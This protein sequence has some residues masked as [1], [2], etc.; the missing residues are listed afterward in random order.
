MKF[1]AFAL[2]ILLACCLTS[3]IEVC[4][5]SPVRPLLPPQPFFSH[6]VLPPREGGLALLRYYEH[7]GDSI[8][9][10]KLTNQLASR[11][12]AGNVNIGDF[13]IGFTYPNF[14]DYDPSSSRQ[15]DTRTGQ[16]LPIRFQN[17]TVFQNN[18][19]TGTLLAP[20]SINNKMDSL[21]E[22]N[23]TPI[24]TWPKGDDSTYASVLVDIFPSITSQDY[25]RAGT[26]YYNIYQLGI[27]QGMYRLPDSLLARAKR[28]YTIRL[29]V[30]RGK[31]TIFPA[32]DSFKS[33][34]FSQT[35]IDEVSWLKKFD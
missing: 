5:C 34:Y 35:S 20:L 27:D 32:N 15:W 10:A 26:N 9:T 19:S 4:G 31:I 28:D 18:L 12:Q 21:L 6:P 17:L 33:F 11:G 30:Q 3:C 8:P 7:D 14:I 25:G 23:E 29:K 22:K 2:V 13:L 24:I 1:I 16:S